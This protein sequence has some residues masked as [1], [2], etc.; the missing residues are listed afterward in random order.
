MPMV[1]GL[2]KPTLDKTR[3][4]DKI[5]LSKVIINKHEYSKSTFYWLLDYYN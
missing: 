3:I 1:E 4:T 5:Q 2:D